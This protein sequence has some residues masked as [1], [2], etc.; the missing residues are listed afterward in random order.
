MTETVFGLLTGR[1]SDTTLNGVYETR[2]DAE[3]AKQ[4]MMNADEENEYGIWGIDYIRILEWEVGKPP[5]YQSD[6]TD[7]WNEVS[8]GL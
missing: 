6:R 2:E 1:Y 8:L 5:V 3:N 4:K 7:E